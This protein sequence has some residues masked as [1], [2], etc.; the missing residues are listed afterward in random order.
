MHLAGEKISILIVDNHAGVREGIRAVIN[1]QPDMVVVGEAKDG[2]EAVRQF[3]KLLPNVT[4]SDVNLPVICG[5]EAIAKIRAEFPLA[6]FIVI[7]ALDD[8]DRINEA[9]AAGARAFLHKD[10]LRRELLPAIRA[11][12]SGQRYV[13]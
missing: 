1:T 4:V 3:K 12:H 10:K 8:D 11:V 13:S 2:L 7:S 9:F 5:I 6:R